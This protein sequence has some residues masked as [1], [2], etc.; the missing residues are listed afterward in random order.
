MVSRCAADA[1]ATIPARLETTDPIFSPGVRPR[2]ANVVRGMSDAVRHAD[3]RRP[4]CQ[5]SLTAS[6]TTR[7]LALVVASTSL[8]A[9]LGSSDDTEGDEDLGDIG[10]GKSD[11]F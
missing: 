7:L 6:L 11:S 4:I 5:P 2:P 9:C 3:M 8:A 1:S 10:D